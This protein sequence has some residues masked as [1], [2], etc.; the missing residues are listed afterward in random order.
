VAQILIKKCLSEKYFLCPL[1]R[2]VFNTVKDSQWQML[3]TVVEEWGLSS[4]FDFNSSPLEIR[5]INGNKFLSRGLDDPKKIKSLTNPSCAWIEE[6]SD[7]DQEDWILILTSLR[8]NY[9]KVQVWATFNPDM[10]T[11]YEETYLYKTFFK[12]TLEL[13]FENSLKIKHNNKNY[14]IKYR[15][16][17]S[18]YK[19]NPFCT[20][21]RSYFYESLK[22]SNE[23]EYRIYA[24]G[25]WGKRVNNA[26]FYSSFKQSIHVKEA[27]TDGS[28]I[29]HLSFDQNVVPYNSC[30]I[31]QVSKVENK[32]IVSFIDEIALKNP[33]N[34]T[35][36]VCN[37]FL[38]RYTD[39]ERIFYYGDATS[40]KRDTR[41]QYN[42][43]DIIAQKLK[44]FISNTSDRV[45]YSNPSVTKRR[46]FL[47]KIF[48]GR[49]P[50]EIVIDPKCKLLIN[51]L[52]SVVEDID[53]TKLKKTTKDKITGQT[54]QEVGHLSD[55]Y[56]YMLVALFKDY[57]DNN[58][59]L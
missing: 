16:T 9:G 39:C 49:F 32:W 53:G 54:Y 40:R 50:I 2:K 51:D 36:D 13:S 48:E 6:A 26:A 43:Y 17:H 34:K 8:S 37:D 52:N 19:D 14:E 27:K 11:D 15:A 46:D 55:T 22:E 30:L 47:N 57:F 31:A 41:S 56:D 20:P 45:P 12:H 24:L 10:P 21:E 33:R 28:K 23:Y 38:L 1:I 29:Y 58:K 7:I 59:F 35:E 18:T 4:L 42:D 3:K 5:C 44:R 25:L